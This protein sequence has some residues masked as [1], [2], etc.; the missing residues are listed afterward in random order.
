MAF[1]AG[2]VR[3]WWTSHVPLCKGWA[4]RGERSALGR[5]PCQQWGNRGPQ[6]D[7][8]VLLEFK[9]AALLES[10]NTDFPVSPAVLGGEKRSPLKPCSLLGALRAPGQES[11]TREHIHQQAPSPGNLG[12][13]HPEALWFGGGL[14]R[15]G[16]PRCSHPLGNALPFPPL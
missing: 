16:I 6:Q 11:Q 7:K 14:A 8:N 5:A 1:T 10:G 3:C 4:P 9:A 12:T 2:S 13:S 15:R